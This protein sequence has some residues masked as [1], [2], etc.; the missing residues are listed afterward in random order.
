LRS[1]G[2]D[3]IRVWDEFM[4]TQKAGP[5]IDSVPDPRRHHLL[6]MK[7]DLLA[8]AEAA[9]TIV[10]RAAAGERGYVCVTNVHM[11][12]MTYDDPTFRTIVNASDF[13]LPDSTILR[14][15]LGLRHRVTPPPS[16]KGADLMLRL[17]AAAER[18][19]LRVAL[20]GGKDHAVLDVLQRKL[21]QRFPNL[22]IAYAYSPPFRPISPDEVERLAAALNMSGAQLVF[23]G[24]GCPKQERWMAQYKPLVRAMMIGVGAA[25][26]FNSGAVTPS[27]GWVHKAGLEWLYRL[28]A[29][30]RRLGRRYLTTSPRF[31]WL[32]ALDAAGLRRNVDLKADR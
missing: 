1:A 5:A 25:F 26:D 29:E 2:V 31:L 9:R 28:A 18:G 11:C 16:E 17:C 23:V 7:V 8:P 14:R 19:H 6:G 32:L 24:L 15:A 4:M 20:I 12:V 10:T 3:A 30:P 21:K 27:P 13:A 22:S